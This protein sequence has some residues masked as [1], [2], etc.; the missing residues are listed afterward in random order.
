MT[1]QQR[2]ALKQALEQH[3]LSMAVKDAAPEDVAA[4]PQDF[5]VPTYNA[6]NQPLY[7][8]QLF[9]AVKSVEDLVARGYATPDGQVTENGQMALSLKKVGALNDDYTLNDTGKTLMASRD[10]LLKEENIDLY[11]EYK[12]LELDESPDVGIWD[13]IKDIASKTVQGANVIAQNELGGI[14]DIAS[15]RVF[16][17][18]FD[19]YGAEALTPEKKAKSRIETEEAAKD[20]FATSAGLARAA[21]TEIDKVAAKTMWDGMMQDY[22]VS[23]LEQKYDRDLADMEKVNTAEVADELAKVIGLETQFAEGRQQAEQLLG[24]EATQQAIEGGRAAGLTL[25]LVNPLAPEA[26]AA[27]VG[28]GVAQKG[29]TAAFKPIARKLLESENKAAQALA[30]NQRV[31]GLN[32]HLAQTQYLAKSAEDQAIF[33]ERQADKLSN[34]GLVDRANAARTLADNL[35]TKGLEAGTRAQG[36]TDEIARASD[37]AVKLAQDAA[38]ADKINF[39]A[40]KARELPGMPLQAIGGLIEGTGKAMIGIDKGLSTLASKIGADK[41]WNAMNRI[42]SLSGLGG[43]GAA[44]G[45]GPAAFIPAAIRTAWSTAPFLK[46]AGHFVRM[47][48]KE[49]A[50]AREL[51]PFWQRVANY[52]TLGATQRSIAHLMD[53]STLGSR[54]TGLAGDV[55]KGMAAA[56]PVD[57]AFQWISDGGE[58]DMN[59]LKQAAAETVVFGGTG[60]ALGGITAA[61]T[62]RIKKLQRGSALNFYRNLK[63]GS[64]RVAFNALNDGMKRSIGT[65]ASSFPNLN[66]K[67]TDQGGGAFDPASN[68][69]FINPMARN[70]LKPLLAHEIN[71]YILVRNQME[72]GVAAA[73]VG[74]GVQTGGLLRG[75]DGKLDENF[76]AFKDEYTRRLEAQHNRQINQKIAAGEKIPAR[77][78]AFTPPT[79]NDIAIEYFVDSMADDM[80]GMAETGELGKQAGRMLVTRKMQSF[81]NA[82]LQQAPIIKDFFYKLG[83]ATDKNGRAVYGNGLLAEGI[84]EIPEM[85]KLFRK[86]ISES[87]GRPMHVAKV[88]KGESDGHSIPIMGKD[89]PIL[90]EMTSLWETDADGVPLRDKNGDY[91]P[92]SDQT[93]Q[94]RASSGLML[95]E[96]QQNRINRGETIEPGELRFNPEENA[97]TGEYLTDRQIQILRTSGRFNNAQLRQLDM[98]N[99]AAKENTGR[100]FLVFNQPAT[101][102]RK[103]KR[104]AYDTLGV[105]MR[106]IVPYG[107]KITRDGNLLV[108]LMSVQQLHANAFE[109]AATKRG[110]ALYKGNAEQILSDVNQVIEN[111]GRNEPT[112]AYFKSRYGNEWEVRKNF[113]NTV[114]G[115]VGKGQ[116][117]INPLLAAEKAK[118]AVVKTYRI[119]RINKAT[120]L[121]G[122]T[123]LPYQNHLVKV[124]FMPEGEPILDENGEPKDLRYTPSYED[125]QV[126]M[127][128]AQRAMPEGEQGGDVTLTRLREIRDGLDE[129]LTEREAIDELDFIIND[130]PSG[131][132]PQDILNK[133]DQAKRDLEEEFTTW[134]GRGDSEA[135][136]ESAISSVMSF[137]DSKES[138]GEAAPTRF[139]PEG[140]D[141]DKFYS[142]LDRV[143]TDKVPTRATAQQIMATIDPTR[144]SGVKADEIKWSGIE[145]ALASLE[146]DGKVSK[147]DLLN[148]LRNEGRVR[149]EEVDVGKKFQPKDLD[150]LRKEAEQSGDFSRYD[151]ALLQNLHDGTKF[152][153]YVLPGG[154]NYR[155]VVL[156]MPKTSG[157]TLR[158]G[159]GDIVGTYKNR[160]EA[161]V[162]LKQLKDSDYL[163]NI[164]P[165][166]EVSGYTS[167][168]F[169]DIPNYVAHM[170]TNERTLD[171]GSEG[172]FVEEF[173][174]DRHQAGRK[175]GYRGEGTTLPQGWTVDEVPTYAYR[176]GPQTGTEWMVFDAS[177]TQVGFGS[178]TRE[179]AILSANS[180]D[181][182]GSVADAPFRTTWPIQL[183]KR[184]LRDAVDGG[185]DWIGFTTA[186]PHIDRWGTE[187]IEWAKQSDGTF[188]INAKSQHGGNAAGIDLEGEADARN[189]NPQNSK[190]VTTEA[191]FVEAIRPSLTEGQNPEALGAKLWKKMATEDSGVSMPRKE[192]FEGFYDNMLPK[193][194]GK[195]VK[196]FGGKV[197]KAEIDIREP[198]SEAWY[199]E[200]TD[201]D[202]KPIWKVNITPEMRKISQTGQMR[203]MPEKLDSDYMKA[204]ES[205]DVEAQ[206]RMVDEA[207]K[208]AGYS[209]RAFHR[210]NS[211]KFSVFDLSKTG[212]ASGGNIKFRKPAVFFTVDGPKIRKLTKMLEDKGFKQGYG[213]REINA[214]LAI[215]PEVDYIPNNAEDGT[216]VAITNA[217]RIKSADPITRDDSGNVIPLSKRFDVGSRD[218]RYMPEGDVEVKVVDRPDETTEQGTPAP[219]SDVQ[220]LPLTGNPIPWDRMLSR[221]VR[222]MPESDR[223]AFPTMTPRLLAEIEKETPTLA[224]IHIDRMRVGEY[225]GID[226]QGGMF[227][228]T[229]KEN[230]DNGVVWAF[231]STGVARTVANRAAQNKGYVKLVLM[232]EGNVV[233]NKTFANIW[234]KI[235]SD[236]IENKQISKALALTELNAARRTVYKT[237]EGKDVKKNPWVAKHADKWNSLEEAKE[238]ILSMPQIE[239]GATYF[240]K[241]KTTTKSEGEKIAYQALLSQ[242]MAKLGFPDAQKIVNDIEEPA[243]K[244]IP[245]G[246]AVAI[247][248]F[249]PL[250]ADEKIMTAKEAGVPEH[251]SYGYVLKGKP[252][253]KLGYYQVVEETFP[254]TKGQIMTQQHTDFPIRAS[255]PSKKSARG[256]IQ[257]ASAIANAAKL[258]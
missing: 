122:R 86:M 212:S 146:K 116:K 166:D 187:R 74:D 154:E 246:A 171:D 35:R 9:P 247:I 135:S 162:E 161:L 70:P 110:Q 83:G 152:S 237:L 202:Y 52:E 42:S 53:T 220:S 174:S 140:V 177:K 251:M 149:F 104:V 50:N 201:D 248:K 71:H 112:D 61:S 4:L 84:R 232:Q 151:E 218:M 34:M 41:A 125:S 30:A 143:I 24:P 40:Q 141:E 253:A 199:K 54:V 28:F 197:E 254:K 204:V 250:G 69:A 207:A 170:R 230:L 31:N 136:T 159:R 51:I 13:S 68:T 128:E 37:E 150:A 43:A 111:H 206:Q 102:K 6:N 205:G 173:Q 22:Q 132:F 99:G 108:R 5:A 219:D 145:Q 77:E 155:E 255:V 217:T 20:L 11:R 221:Q 165:T 23:Y 93:E 126:R 214:Y 157:Y 191:Q 228:P 107:I 14:K 88:T 60:A 26:L 211:D 147:D 192:G 98:L 123:N 210:T 38:V 183:F 222:F 193:E 257:Y 144:G 243:F 80:M 240:K 103:G 195:Y 85:K 196:Q 163:A 153:Q 200:P 182:Q 3:S 36:L 96:D 65:Y 189:L 79:D 233:G 59:T 92:L 48:G 226:L 57:L 90:N 94:L 109:K 249:D 21:A 181:L 133:V 117:D 47:I 131:Y 114:F 258:K 10:D 66:I 91:I 56:Y 239:R 97:W 244:G 33:A 242:K 32:S 138:G 168:H 179:E 175:K 180:G 184:A 44:M 64:Q 142:Q 148:Y 73:L 245:T 8:N 19:Q 194:V 62:D 45:L 124:N 236:A 1:P 156:A 55:A 186:Q 234:F 238:A 241:S 119:D 7:D 169:H 215:D 27:R 198:S 158:N 137:L 252:V 256:Q 139:M 101:K 18:A 127:P 164:T 208:R 46:G 17:G 2:D 224:A 216:E 167:S 178:K 235:L 105:S 209:V 25:S 203:F 176:G 39:V 188:L 160:E 118:N 63:D 129:N 190:T 120:E 76:Q 49:T 78:R 223:D 231:N 58:M 89:D 72:G 172:L 115:N 29:V 87:A 81:G 130:A 227:Y 82:I 67:F 213:S 185:K 75:K 95:L 229:I 134:A 113:I 12:R 121:E 100:R 106:E 15:S 225:M 16:G